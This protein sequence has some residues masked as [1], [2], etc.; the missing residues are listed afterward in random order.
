MLLSKP[1]SARRHAM[2]TPL[3]SLLI[4][5]IGSSFVHAQPSQAQ[6]VQPLC[7]N[8]IDD[9]A[10][11]PLPGMLRDAVREAPRGSTITFDPALN[12]RTIKL[13]ASS[14]KNQIRI[15]RD[16][17]LQGPGANLLAI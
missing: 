5:C 17:T 15:P 3:L 8:R 6:C 13:D 16:V 14:P 9:R 4:V 12:G 2:R 7:V 1:G 11:D 10:D